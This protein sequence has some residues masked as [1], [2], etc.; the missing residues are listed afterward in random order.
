M[1]VDVHKMPAADERLFDQLNKFWSLESIGITE[2]ESEKRNEENSEMIFVVV[3]S[4]TDPIITFSYRG[5]RNFMDYR[6]ILI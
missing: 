5:K 3:Y 1:K 6:I 4:S 2:S